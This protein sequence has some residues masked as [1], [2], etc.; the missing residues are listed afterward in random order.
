VRP[1]A[2]VLRARLYLGVNAED[3]TLHFVHGV[4]AVGHRTQV[5]P[6]EHHLI[7]GQGS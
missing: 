2:Q 4:Q 6:L 5:Q 7:L 1:L 3:V